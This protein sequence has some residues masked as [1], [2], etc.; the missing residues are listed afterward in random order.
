M[1]VS[2]GYDERQKGWHIQWRCHG[3]HSIRVSNAA[4]AGDKAASERVARRLQ[5]HIEEA[6]NR[7]DKGLFRLQ[8]DSFV[9]EELNGAAAADSDRTRCVA[10]NTAAGTMPPKGQGGIEQH[11]TAGTF[12]AHAKR[13][14]YKARGP[15]RAAR[16]AADEDRR[17]LCEASA[18]G[19]DAL[20][21][22][23]QRLLKEAA[24]SRVPA[25][26]S[27]RVWASRTGAQPSIAAPKIDE[28]FASLHEQE[29][30]QEQL[31]A[32]NP[33]DHPSRPRPS[34]PDTTDPP[35]PP[36]KNPSLLSP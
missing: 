4:V 15:F 8:L 10:T 34:D 32:A 9:E 29:K 6:P 7:S 2:C 22:A 33:L 36:S 23:T 18:Q 20:M 30:R 3:Q 14:G 24:D 19:K 35:D 11:P 1:V 26:A 31:Q 28:E 17:I 5:R 13:E 27:E 16:S 12:R 21:V 25:E